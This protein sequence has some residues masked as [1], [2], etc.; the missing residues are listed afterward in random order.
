M[1]RSKIGIIVGLSAEAKLLQ[2]TSFM[3]EIGGGDPPGAARAAERLIAKNAVALIS[4]GLAGGLNP[5]LRPGAVLIPRTVI[6]GP[7]VYICDNNLI[8]MLGGS[9]SQSVSSSQR[10]AETAEEK[11]LLF[12]Q[13]MADAVDLE[14]GAVGRVAA[15]NRLPFAVLRAVADPAERN[16]PA[17]ALIALNSTGDIKISAVLASVFKQPGQIPVLLAIA[18]D[19][20]K[21]PRCADKKIK[22]T[23]LEK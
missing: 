1:D 21:S 16:L 8:D 6:D 17:A 19:A 18:Q 10:I 2:H 23:K 3:V 11:G 5:T 20:V 9:N 4:F 14:S 7:D 13:T 22:T 12:S 15:A